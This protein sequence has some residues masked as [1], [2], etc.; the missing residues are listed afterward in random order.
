[1]PHWGKSKENGIWWAGKK[2]RRFMFKDH[3]SLYIAL[4]HY[5]LRIMK[6]TSQR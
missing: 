4:G 1:M 2:R 3:D 5:R 6:P